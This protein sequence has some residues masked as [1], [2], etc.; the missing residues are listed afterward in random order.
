MSATPSQDRELKPPLTEGQMLREE[1]I[2]LYGDPRPAGADPDAPPPAAVE[3]PPEGGAGGGGGGAAACSGA[4]DATGRSWIRQ[5]HARARAGQRRTAL[6]LSG[7]GIR[8]ATFGLG[9]LQ[10]LAKYGLLRHFDYLSSVSGGGYVGSWLTAWLHRD[11]DGTG[12]VF[13]GLENSAGPLRADLAACTCPAMPS[14]AGGEGGAGSGRNQWLSNG[15]NSNE[16]LQ[17]RHLREYSNYLTPRVG[18]LRPDGWTLVATYFRNLFLNWLVILPLAVAVL[19]LP[20]VYDAALLA[21]NHWAEP[22]ARWKMW[23]YG[24]VSLPSIFALVALIGGLPSVNRKPAGIAGGSHAHGARPLGAGGDDWEETPAR[25]P[26]PL[27]TPRVVALM[28]LPM[29]FACVVASFARAWF[30]PKGAVERYS[31]VVS[32]CAGYYVIAASLAAVYTRWV[33]KPNPPALLPLLAILVGAGTVTGVVVAWSRGWSPL[34]DV[35]V[36]PN[37]FACLVVPTLLGAFLLVLTLYAGLSSDCA[38]NDD[39][40]EWLA[41]ISA[42]TL[43][44]AFCWVLVCGVSMGGPWLWDWS[45]DHRSKDLIRSTWAIGSAVAT[46]LGLLGGH[47]QSSAAPA[48]SRPSRTLRERIG[49]VIPTVAAPIATLAIFTILAILTA[50]LADLVIRVDPLNFRGR[51]VA[52]AHGINFLYSGLLLLVLAGLGTVGGCLMNSNR[53]SLHAVYRDRLIRAF[54]GASNA[55]RNPN[56]FTGFDP[57]DNLPMH[58]LRRR[59]FFTRGDLE[60]P[61]HAI[62]RWWRVD[63]V[64]RMLRAHEEPFTAW[65]WGKASRQIPTLNELAK[66]NAGTWG[67]AGLQPVLDALNA[68]LSEHDLLQESRFKDPSVRRQ[69]PEIEWAYRRWVNDGSCHLLNRVILE[70][71]FCTKDP[72]APAP[73]TTT[74]ATTTTATATIAE[75]KREGGETGAPAASVRPVKLVYFLKPPSSQGCVPR[76]LHVVNVALNL[77]AGSNLAWQQRKAASFTIS[78]LHCGFQRGYRPSVEYAGGISL[79]TAMTISGAAATPNM[80]YHSSPAVTFLMTLFNVRLGWWL[81]NPATVP[82]NWFRRLLSALFRPFKLE[83]RPSPTGAGT[84]YRRPDPIHSLVPLLNEALGRTT[85]SYRYVYLSD[86][87]HFENLGIYETVRRRCHVVVVSDASCDP[88]CNFD[89]LGNAIRK[90]QIDLGI[91]VAIKEILFFPK[92]QPLQKGKYCAV[93]DIYYSDVDGANAVNGKLIYLKPA[94]HELEPVDVYNFGET[95]KTFPH[96][97][98]SNQWF[99][100]S[101]FESYRKLGL[102]TIDAICDRRD[103]TLG[104]FVDAATKHA[105]KR[106]ERQVRAWERVPAV[107]VKE[108]PAKESPAKESPVKESPVKESPVKESSAAGNLVQQPIRPDTAVPGSIDARPEGGRTVAAV[109]TQG[110]KE[111]TA[112]PGGVAAPQ[113]QGA[114][115]APTINRGGHG[116]PQTQRVRKKR[117]QRR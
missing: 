24:L 103:M 106:Y 89:D 72:P 102:E 8:S 49:H 78:P 27:S 2:G 33:R 52:G 28:I 107:P 43:L 20:R 104:Q 22:P 94:R 80:G 1:Y 19:L 60:D 55:D 82:E 87:G 50:R 62:N 96:D 6:C 71:T 37:A 54:L 98:T 100:E 51:G 21:V 30:M 38:G 101:Q 66:A 114:S 77:V 92:A 10:G 86:G 99:N 9:V 32:F 68:F 17:I 4:G 59:Q 97:A 81:G 31:F 47:A 117:R 79:G 116:Q 14:A 53:L 69:Y 112:P 110:Q 15:R 95:N 111:A 84:E 88:D 57:H 75:G 3:E 23:F 44:I 12:T 39:D 42:W 90:V 109:P 73:T 63:G 105:E 41:R 18:L 35:T 76:P 40:R 26:L 5:I 91:R 67:E 113:P 65:L 108:S 29:V 74:T 58:H 93:G 36:H 85:D 61:Q 115:A 64:A 45:R 7:G 16:P 56:P 25:A 34:S 46:I 48:Y 83:L 13:Q 70:E 11:K